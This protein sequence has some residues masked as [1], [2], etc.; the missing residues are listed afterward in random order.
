MTAVR[1]GE[2]RLIHV[3][4]L[5]AVVG[6]VA[7]VVLAFSGVLAVGWLNQKNLN[8]LVD[9]TTNTAT[10]FTPAKTPTEA[11]DKFHDAIQKRKYKA[12]ALYVTKPYAD[13]LNRANDDAV[14]LGAEIDRILRY[15][16]NKKIKTDKLEFFLLS[17]DPF[18]KNFKV[19][20]APVEKGGRATASYTFELVQLKAPP[21]ELKDMDFAMFVSPLRAPALVLGNFELVKEGE[22]W[23]INVPITPQFEQTVSYC[24]DKWKTYH[25]GLHSLADDLSRERYDT[26]AG[27]ESDVL[28]KLRAA[29]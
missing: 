4:I 18:P 29:K 27:L 25:T 12:A 20:A 9:D 26:K 5:G 10:G 22:E 23:K 2:V 6:V 8:K 16:D 21:T 28:A 14:E 1:A 24:K 7:V 15:A 11:M 19:G 17:L 3:L 13:Q